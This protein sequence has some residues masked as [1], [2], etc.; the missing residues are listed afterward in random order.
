MK[1]IRYW[2]LGFLV[3]SGCASLSPDYQQPQIELISFAP[4]KSQGFEQRFLI[5]LRIVNPNARGLRVR[6]LVYQLRLNGRRVVSGVSGN[7]PEVPAYGDVAIELEAG[8]SLIGGARFIYDLV[9]EGKESI[10]YELEARLDLGT[11]VP[12]VKVVETGQVSFGQ[13]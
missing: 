3:L 4:V 1:K 11:F 8:A 10:D 7:I 2:W 13:R 9:Q 6:G 5:G 12:S